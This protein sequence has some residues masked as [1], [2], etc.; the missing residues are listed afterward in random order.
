L[1]SVGMKFAH[2]AVVVWTAPDRLTYRMAGSLKEHMLDDFGVTQR[3]SMKR[4]R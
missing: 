2:G 3:S 1:K 4:G